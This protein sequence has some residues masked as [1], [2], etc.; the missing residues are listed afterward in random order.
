MSEPY[1]IT[2]PNGDI[3]ARFSVEQDRD[4]ALLTGEYSDDAEPAYE[5]DPTEDPDWVDPY[6][7]YT[8]KW[9]HTGSGDEPGWQDSTFPNEY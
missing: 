6:E 1:L 3:L 8:E 7:G 2:E 9:Y 5:S 4:D